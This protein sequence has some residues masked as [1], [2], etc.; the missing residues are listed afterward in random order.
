[1][2]TFPSGMSC[3][4]SQNYYFS[5]Q[6]KYNSSQI[7]LLDVARKSIRNIIIKLKN[8]N[9]RQLNFTKLLQ[10]L[11]LKRIQFNYPDSNS[12]I[13]NDLKNKNKGNDYEIIVSIYWTN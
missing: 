8:F 9:A 10:I 7:N 6:F 11:H 12:F 3:K 2:K 5:L 13:L 1:M 4:Y